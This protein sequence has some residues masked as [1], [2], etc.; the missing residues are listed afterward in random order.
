MSLLRSSQ[1]VLI[2]FKLPFQNVTLCF[3]AVLYTASLNKHFSLQTNWIPITEELQMKG[4]YNEIV[5]LL[6]SP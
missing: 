3:F 2:L 6:I 1:L 4:L 5:M